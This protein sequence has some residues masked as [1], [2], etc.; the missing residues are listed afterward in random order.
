[1]EQAI[2]AIHA[3]I[4]RSAVCTISV[5]VHDPA[6]GEYAAY[7][8]AR[9]T[10]AMAKRPVLEAAGDAFAHGFKLSENAARSVFTELQGKEYRV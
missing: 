6:T 9:A 4:E 8:Q 5:L 2:V 7:R 1:M 3:S 10:T